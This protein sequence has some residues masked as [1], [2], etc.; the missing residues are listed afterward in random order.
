MLMQVVCIAT[1]VVWEVNNLQHTHS[2][3]QYYK[4]L[5]LWICIALRRDI[6]YVIHRD[7]LGKKVAWSVKVTSSFPSRHSRDVSAT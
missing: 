4:C 5:P 6:D 3:Q 7:P 1:A 2:V